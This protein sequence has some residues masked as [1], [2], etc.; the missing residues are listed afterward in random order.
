[1]IGCRLYKRTSKCDN[2]I[3]YANSST[4]VQMRVASRTIWFTI[5]A[6]FAP[7]ATAWYPFYPW[8]PKRYPGGTIPGGT[9]P[10]RTT[11]PGQVY[12]GGSNPGG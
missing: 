9:Q 7:L 12:P 5:F 6:I 4:G 1:M 3:W 2:A 11:L 8:F 10:G